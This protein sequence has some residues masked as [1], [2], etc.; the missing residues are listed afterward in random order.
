[1]Q[2]A[3]VI[4][5]REP[6]CQVV[7]DDRQASRHHARILQT[8]DGYVLEDLGSKNGTY[9]NGQPLTAPRCSRTAT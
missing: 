2:R 6:D 3:A 5:G 1:L 4:I 8:E 7:V 9:L